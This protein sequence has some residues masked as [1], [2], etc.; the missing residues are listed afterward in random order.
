MTLAAS[1]PGSHPPRSD[2]STV[3]ASIGDLSDTPKYNIKAVS[4]ETGIRAV[5]L[6]AWERRYK[7]LRPQRTHSNYRLYSERDIALLRWVKQHV[8]SGFSI[9][10]AAAEW[11]EMRRAGKWPMPAV[12]VPR[13][14][15]APSAAVPAA[16]LAMRLYTALLAHDEASA[17]P[18]LS[19]AFSLYDVR[20]VALEVMMPCLH[21]IGDAW[22]RGDIRIA[23]EHF[24]SNYL[25]GRLLTL[26][27]SQPL[28]R[29]GAR[30]LVGSA[31]HEFHDIGGLMLALLL[32]RE[33]Y[34]VEFLGQDVQVDDLLEYARQERPALICMA[35]AA[36]HSARELR[37]LPAGLATMRPRPLFGFGGPAF[38]FYPKLRESIPGVFLG[39][40]L[41]AAVQKVHK[42]LRS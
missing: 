19:E 11:A 33:G 13:P 42:I 16:T 6:R 18:V 29:S 34:R 3:A 12:E 5:T 23:T 14:T 9:S 17:G 25:R 7:L 32:R 1:L 35:A 20:A 30:I 10:A 39:E 24:A 26:F 21:A 41:D 22:E 31:P 37:R 4:A 38:N 8:D 2:S 15:G 27:Q 36:E 28:N 40:T